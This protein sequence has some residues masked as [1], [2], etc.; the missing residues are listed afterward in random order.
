MQG[1]VHMVQIR[2]SIRFFALLMT[3]IMMITACGKKSDAFVSSEKEQTETE[4]EQTE[5][6][7]WNDYKKEIEGTLTI[8]AG[9][10][11]V[12]LGSLETNGIMVTLPAGTF[13][14]SVKITLKNPDTAPAYLEEEML[15]FGAPFEIS[16]G[17][18]PVRLL[19]P[20]TITMKY[21]PSVLGEDLEN[22]ALYYAYYNG[23]NWEYIKPVVDEQQQTITFTTCHFSLFSKAKLTM[24]QR[25]DQYVGNA[26]VA[27][28]AKEQANTI[29]DEALNSAIDHIL[30]EKLKIN[31]DS[32]TGK[33]LAGIKEDSEWINMLNSVKDG[34]PE[35]FNQNLQVLLGKKIV[36]NVSESTLSSALGA[37]TDDA[38]I[39]VVAK[40]G[41]AAGYLAEGRYKDAA[42][43]IG[44]QIADQFMITKVGKFAVA[45][46]DSQ[47]SSWKNEEIEAAYQVYKN[48]ASSTVP[49]WG[50]QVEKGN[51]DDVWTQ[52]GGAARQL[53]LEA[54]KSQNQAREE[55]G[56]PFLTSEEENKLREGVRK[57]LKAQF[58][59][60][61]KT[62]AEIE[63]KEQELEMIMKMYQEAGFLEKGRWGWDKE[64]ELETRL[65]VLVHFKDKLL[66]DTGR[67]DIKSGSMHNEQSIGLEQLKT[68]A[69]KWFSTQDP[70]ERQKAYE[71]Y[72]ESEFGIKMTPDVSEIN[73]LW[74][75]CT[76]T[77]TEYDI[78]SPPPPKEES[79]EEGEELGCDLTSLDVYN[80]VKASLEENKDKPM[81]VTMEIQIGQD[82]NGSVN[83]IDEEGEKTP[84]QATYKSGTIT[85]SIDQ[86]G[87]IAVFS[88]YIK[89]QGETITLSGGFEISLS[90]GAWVKGSWEGTK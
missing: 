71:E 83:I 13:N 31:D 80:M 44:E 53:E 81:P 55:A 2:R 25:I 4:K 67:T 5:T 52:M 59:K 65:D 1:G 41:E 62:D 47:I 26:A 14:E 16:A 35:T 78:G 38:G 23:T 33:V 57:D 9:E 19:Q 86:E 88:G 64:Y 27:D 85:A 51:F 29:T 20:V 82:G 21:D 49:W 48:G 58:E 68:I 46:I 75:S 37:I 8:T 60:R 32:L 6:S 66:Q 69:M 24:D 10:E 90:E 18:S 43:I 61:I 7:G 28:W 89:R 34:D 36:E 76:M 72:L 22:G 39:E 11:E 73:G 74:S 84:M 77:I 3:V 12:T 79:E 54:I 56:M 50:Y 15:G 40:A 17:E 45:A 42:K 63:K 70:E 30:K 87:T